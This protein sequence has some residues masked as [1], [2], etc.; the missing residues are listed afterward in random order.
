V[1][2]VK[3]AIEVL[4][5]ERWVL[6]DSGARNSYVTANVA[7]GLPRIDL[8]QERTAAL[9]GKL[10][11][12]RQACLVVG[13]IDGHTF[14]FNANVIDEIGKDEDGRPIEVLFGAVAMQLWGIRLDIKAEQLDLSHHSDDF[15][16][17]GP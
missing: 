9:G 7:E 16:E 15:V 17:F 4:G 3:A 14:E 6:F 10:H 8:P 13:R 5:Q 11:K 2:R 1:G 12:L